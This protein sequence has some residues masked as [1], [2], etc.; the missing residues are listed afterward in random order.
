MIVKIMIRKIVTVIVVD[1]NNIIIVTIMII[2]M[3]IVII[4]ITII[5]IIITTTTL[6]A[7]KA[8]IKSLTINN[9]PCKIFVKNLGFVEV[10]PSP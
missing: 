6:S 7:F 3:M 1:N 9:C 8:K 2:M 10:C 4:I 5:I